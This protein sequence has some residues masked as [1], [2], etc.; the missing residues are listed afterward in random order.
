[1]DR[2]DGAPVLARTPDHMA[3]IAGG[4]FRMGS[5]AHYPEER[6]A[7]GVMV[8]GFWIDGHSVTNADFAILVAATGYITFAERPL[9]PAPYPGA[10]PELP[11]PGSGE[12]RMPNRPVRPRDLRDWWEYV[13]RADSRHPHGPSSTIA[14][15]EREPVVHRLRGRRRVR[16]LGR[17]GSG[18]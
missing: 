17:Q 1:M 10:R 14:G 16:G 2:E 18:D 9:D 15:R 7:H 11:A 4:T 8:D 3:G 6:P 12:F 13:P 5:D